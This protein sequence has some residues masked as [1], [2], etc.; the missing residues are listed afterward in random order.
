[1]SATTSNPPEW[2]NRPPAAYDIVA[3]FYPE[4]SPRPGTKKL[5]PCLVTQVRQNADTGAHACVVVFGTTHLK[6]IQRQHLDIIVQNHED[7]TAFGLAM[8]TRFDL[9][10]PVL[11]PW[12]PQFFGCWR[13]RPSPIIGSLTADY[14]RDYAFKMLRRG[15]VPRPLS[16]RGAK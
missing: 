7:V 14:V 6:V 8:P 3:A 15:S 9:D 5:C 12:I 13:G 11:L 4:T 1:M 2:V 10:S 16:P